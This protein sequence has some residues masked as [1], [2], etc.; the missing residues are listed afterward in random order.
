MEIT[1]KRGPTEKPKYIPKVL[2][3]EILVETEEQ[4]KSI[5]TTCQK[6]NKTKN[7]GLGRAIMQDICDALNDYRHVEDGEI[8]V[9][10]VY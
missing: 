3:I 4:E 7:P 9:E 2:N 8:L 6:L 5:F 10:D 1:I